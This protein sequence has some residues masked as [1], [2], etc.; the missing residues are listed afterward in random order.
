MNMKHFILTLAAAGSF[1]FCLSACDTDS[2]LDD[3]PSSDIIV[4]QSPEDFQAI[5]DYY[6][7][8]YTGAFA[9][10]SSDNYYLQQASWTAL[11]SVDKNS[12]IWAKDIYEGSTA[13]VSDWNSL[14]VEVYAA[15]VVL[16]GI[17]ANAEKGAGYGLVK[18][19]ALFMRAYA[20]FNLAQHFCLPYDEESYEQDPG[21][22]LR[23]KADVNI[24]EQRA[25]VR[26]TYERILED[27]KE[28]LA[29]S[30]VLQ[31]GTNLNRPCKAAIYAML[32]RVYLSMRKY[33]QSTAYA[34]SSLSLYNTLIDYN[35][36][37]KTSNTPFTRNPAEVL[38]Q[39][40]VPSFAT[41]LLSSSNT[42]SFIDTALYSSYAANDLRKSVFFRSRTG[43]YTI[44][45]GYNGTTAAF[46]GLAVDEM[47]LNRAE[48]YARAGKAGQAM[49][50]LNYLLIRRF[51]SSS[52]YVPLSASSPS[53]VLS[54][55]LTERRKEL[56]WRGLR[57]IDIRRL[58]KEGHNISLKRVIGET[59]YTLEPNSIRY[60]LPV[61]LQEISI[62]N[63]KQNER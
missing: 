10:I 23:L 12:Y 21:L 35:T 3:K 54:L 32:S 30:T 49:N 4:P 18:S 1:I 60:A 24:L 25:S 13:E 42:I 16:D 47:Y 39:S 43:G 62:S 40:Y 44:K 58:N 5:L 33:D 7:L 2:F 56:I 29:L 38:Y 8:N 19:N 48:G 50:D 52:G 26:I 41:S 31:P 37:S 27:L 20:F 55:I 15:N 9:E 17:A 6:Y 34:D 53:E 46:T 45:G 51:N 57:W 36:L 28:S 14:Y 59:T 63:I 22:P 11:N 61:P